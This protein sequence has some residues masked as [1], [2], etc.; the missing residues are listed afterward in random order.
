VSGSGDD[1]TLYISGTFTSNI[2]VI[3]FDGEEA[4]TPT[5]ITVP[6]QAARMGIA[7]VADEDSLW[8]NQPGG[9]LMKIDLDG[10]VG[11]EIS[12]DVLASGFGDIAYFEWKVAS[13]SSPARITRHS[14]SSWCST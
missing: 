1:V 7:R 9:M 3:P 13:T 6:D 4:G 2:A 5:Y 8:I 12:T 11:R 14:T 10:N